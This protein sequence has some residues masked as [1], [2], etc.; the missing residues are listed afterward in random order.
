MG[1][2]KGKVDKRTFLRPGFRVF[3]EWTTFGR[4]HR[5]DI[6][7]PLPDDQY[8]IVGIYRDTT[9]KEGNVCKALVEFP[10][11]SFRCWLDTPW[12]LAHGLRTERSK[13]I[14]TSAL[15]SP[16]P[17]PTITP[18]LGTIPPPQYIPLRDEF[19]QLD[20]QMEHQ[21]ESHG[22]KAG[23][24]IG[25]ININGLQD[26]DIPLIAW[27]TSRQD[28]GILI[29]TD[30]RLR[31]CDHPRIRAIWT[32][33]IPGGDVQFSK[34]DS[35]C[36]GGIAFFLDSTWNPRRIHNWNDPSGLGSILELTFSSALGKV[37][38]I[39]TYWPTPAT[40][41]E[42]GSE[43]LA[44]RLDTWLRTNKLGLTPDEYMAKT[45]Q[46]R[47]KKPALLHLIGGDLNANPHD[48]RLQDMAEWGIRMAHNTP[49]FTR[50][51]GSRGTGQIDHLMA[52]M[53]PIGTGHTEYEGLRTHTDHRP[54]WAR[55]LIAPPASPRV[56]RL[57]KHQ[58]KT[59]K[60]EDMPTLESDLQVAVAQIQ[61]L[62]PGPLMESLTN[63][64][65]QAFRQPIKV[66]L[67]YW[68]PAMRVNM[69]WLAMHL[70]LKRTRGSGLTIFDKY[71]QMAIRIGPDAEIL[72]M[73]LFLPLYP[74][75][76]QL[77]LA[78][79]ET[80]IAEAHAD[81][82]GRKRKEQYEAI[83]LASKRR[84]KDLKRTF[85]SLG[86]KPP[87]STMDRIETQDTVFTDPKQIQQMVSD[88]FAQWFQTTN[89]P[90][91]PDLWSCVQDKEAF[92]S[93]FQS[94]H[95][96]PH[97]LDVFY[98]AVNITSPQENQQDLLSTIQG[99]TP[100]EFRNEVRL[101]PNGRSGGPSGLTYDMLK[102]IPDWTIDLI[103]NKMTTLWEDKTTPTWLRKKWLCPIP[104]D[105]DSSS[106]DKLR[107]IMLIEVIRKLWTG[108][109]IRKL[110]ESW[111]NIWF[112]PPSNTAS[113]LR[114]PA[115]RPYYS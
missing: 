87:R 24:G 33:L 21:V 68:S 18:S 38:I 107:P 11:I 44:H 35:H 6:P 99:P 40:N 101:A 67:H 111:E 12:I 45:L 103:H 64:I 106:L 84:D 71:R 47:G 13:N 90:P 49:F 93:H 115:P 82:S 104:K 30:T 108:T 95:L 63:T 89:Q 1:V 79:L 56:K 3:V 9:L 42:D 98:D 28:L 81:L 27:L 7:L 10:A 55:Y 41:D 76:I 25:T 51:S 105:P 85:K 66:K 110:R 29:C 74:M 17:P 77:P 109:I 113:A 80:T 114:D 14:L 59:R 91:P 20:M 4:D 73:E 57:A 78:L 62:S 37:R 54:I 46:Q 75:N 36:T 31:N 94:L 100:E 22:S 92:L 96:P 39:G 70:E 83:Q 34:A 58:F 97:L 19:E 50:F 60:I 23:T 2:V 86:G 88:H 16:P 8:Q 72:W 112:S 65:V 5:D 48:R 32:E 15:V 61:H 53:D 52:N 69:L 43:Q 26:Y 102:A